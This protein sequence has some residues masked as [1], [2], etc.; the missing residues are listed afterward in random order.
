M[1]S[2]APDHTEGDS[3]YKTTF[4]YEDYHSHVSPHSLK[5]ASLLCSTA[6][7][8]VSLSGLW[9]GL[10]SAC[11]RA[12]VKAGSPAA[13]EPSSDLVNKIAGEPFVLQPHTIT[14]PHWLRGTIGRQ[15]RSIKV[16]E[17]TLLQDGQFLKLGKNKKEE[18]LNPTWS[19]WFV[20]R[21]TQAL[22]KHRF[23]VTGWKVRKHQHNVKLFL[24]LCHRGENLA[25]RENTTNPHK[26]AF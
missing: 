7:T 22:Q 21:A 19:C 1:K 25:E 9:T 10:A 3:S 20:W 23:I 2:S 17:R 12:R 24:T 15:V 4:I 16:S 14:L 5:T 11:H 6:A 26:A 13:M 8:C 18:V